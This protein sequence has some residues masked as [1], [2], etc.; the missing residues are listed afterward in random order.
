MNVEKIIISLIISLTY[1][2]GYAIDFRKDAFIWTFDDYDA[3]VIKVISDE[4]VNFNG[5][6]QY[7]RKG[8]ASSYELENTYYGTF[9]DGS[10]WETKKII[11]LD[12][13]EL[14]SDFFSNIRRIAGQSY[15]T[16]NNILSFNIFSSGICKIVVKNIKPNDKGN[17]ILHS[18]F[19]D[20]DGIWKEATSIQEVSGDG[21]YELSINGHAQGS[22][23]ISTDISVALY[24]V[25]FIPN[26]SYKLLKTLEKPIY[27]ASTPANNSFF[28]FGLDAFGQV[29]L[30]LT[31]HSNND[32]VYVH[33]GEC[34]IGDSVDRQ[35]GGS[36][37]Y[38]CIKL[39]LKQ[40]TNTYNPELT[41]SKYSNGLSAIYM[42]MEIGEV[43]PFRYCEVEC[44][45]QPLSADD[46]VRYSVHSEFNESSSH[47]LSDN[48]NLNKIWDLCKYSMKAT[49][50]IGYYVDG[51]RERCPY[52][53][54]ALINQLSH[55]AC[56]NNYTLSHRTIEYLL[57]NP[58][59]PTEWI[60]QTVM[61]AWNDYIF[62]GDLQILTRYT[63]LLYN[64]TLIGFINPENGLLTT[65]ALEQT[66]EKLSSIN[67]IDVLRDIVDWPHSSASKVGEDDGF[68]YSDYNAVVNA[69][70]YKACQTMANIYTILQNEEA[71]K[72]LNDYCLEFR[73]K[74]N[75]GF[76][77]RNVGLYKDGIT[78]NHYSLHSNMFALCFDLVPDEFRES[79]SAYIASKGLSCSVYGAQFLLEALFKNG[80]ASKGIDLMTNES[81]RG[82]M[83]MIYEGST[84]TTEAWSSQIKPNQDWNH[85]WGACPANIIQFYLIGIRPVESNFSKILIQPKIGNLN[86]VTTKY[87]TNKGTIEITIERS[88]KGIMLDLVIPEEID[89]DIVLS[90]SDYYFENVLLDGMQTFD[91]DIEEGN[92]R[93]RS[94]QGRHMIVLTDTILKKQT[95]EMQKNPDN[96]YYDILGRKV[97]GCVQKGLYI[98][99]HKKIVRT[100]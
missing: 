52:E 7:R 64:H 97:N 35:P 100:D 85:A 72:K 43:T 2:W 66:K 45:S 59:W 11:Y 75:D 44:Y 4:I 39:P 24:A 84:I 95:L 34:A 65:T 68:V 12:K 74:F 61:M 92:I 31:S 36:R 22:F 62:S 91:F 80:Y 94:L 38:K 27:A 13:S 90:K 76:L 47:F 69:Y 15:S 6:Y 96:I 83:N 23:W 57:L 9:S 93:L 32:T 37:S 60:M 30:T 14:P 20:K 19:K 33:L 56:D 82:W 73:I 86:Y 71:A 89:A 77:D 42:P 18:Q 40:G 16:L 79:V 87:P 49:S 67:R 28:D 48:D 63:D 50:F 21:F 3:K 88:E 58:T 26:D 70:H 98:N 99:N 55:F 53:A 25:N 81:L 29:E 51:D 5:L 1:L 78:D 10:S 41:W 8:P 54:D 17:V 46:I